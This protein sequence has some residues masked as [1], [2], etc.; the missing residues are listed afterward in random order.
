MKKYP[1]YFYLFIYL[2]P[3]LFFVLLESG[4]RIFN[5]GE[6]KEQWIRPFVEYPEIVTLNYNIANRY[7]SKIKN[8]PKPALDGFDL[9]KKSN[10]FRIFVFGESSAAGYPYDPNA[11]FSKYI[12]Q[13]LQLEYPES[14]IEVINLSMSAI[15]SYVLLDL[16]PG[17]IEYKPDLVLIYTG[18]NEYYGA[19]GVASTESISQSR[20]LIKFVLWAE[21]FKI[22]ELLKNSIT[23][24]SYAFSDPD[25]SP[26]TLMAKMVGNQSISFKSELYYEG[27]E[28]FHDNMQEI[29]NIMKQNKIPIIIGTL[30]SNLKDL[31]PFISEKSDSF[32]SANQVFDEAKELWIKGDFKESKS[33]F[34]FAKDLDLLRFRAPE[35]INKIIL[36]LGNKNS[37]PVVKV[38]SIFTSKS[39]NGI[40]GNELMTD[41]LHPNY[42]GQS[43]IGEGYINQME[44]YHFL[45]KTPVSNYN[46]DEIDSFMHSN[47]RYTELDSLIADFR[48]KNLKINWPFV[49]ISDS[50]LH[51]L[52]NISKKDITDSLAFFVYENGSYW[53]RAHFTLGYNYLKK[54][55][56][57]QYLNEMNAIIFESPFIVSNYFTVSTELMKANRFDEALIYLLQQHKL[58]PD[59]YTNKWIGTIKVLRGKFAEAIPY[60][61]NS[62][63]LNPNDSRVIYNLAVSYYNTQKFPESLAKVNECLKKNPNYIEAKRLKFILDDLL[64]NRN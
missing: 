59:D 25:N 22:T 4:L 63:N 37:I 43:L 46:R 31:K 1:V 15:S 53:E 3:V 8:I 29:I 16:A 48:I 44:S 19:L 55:N 18:H 62:Y 61:Q 17:I 35:D 49:P 51:T 11:A 39:S 50:G 42:Y 6:N 27:L 47:K 60:L 40:I 38:D 23:R 64:K 20:T 9:N 30:V 10:S 12:K 24:I 26:S 14:K 5:Y 41:H 13:K 57:K 7:F 32:P 34:T 28:Q 2:I 36:E 45:P 54:G 56:I 58:K 21:Q 52:N 33:K